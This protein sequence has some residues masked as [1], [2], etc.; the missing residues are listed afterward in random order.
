M[1]WKTTVKRRS[2]KSKMTT[3]TK[4]RMSKTEKTKKESMD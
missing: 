2:P 4:M 1:A 3:T